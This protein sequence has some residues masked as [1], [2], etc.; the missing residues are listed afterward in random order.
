MYIAL[1][2]LDM[3]FSNK[4]HM[5]FLMP[6]FRSIIF[7]NYTEEY[8]CSKKSLLILAEAKYKIIL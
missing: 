3:P 8:V 2:T 1:K 6:I 7:N 4:K 5:A